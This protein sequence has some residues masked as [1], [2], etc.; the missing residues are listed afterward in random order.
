MGDR[1]PNCNGQV[2]SW[3]DL[4]C[5][6]CR[7]QAPWG[8]VP[9]GS[10]SSSHSV[11]PSFPTSPIVPEALTTHHLLRVLSQLERGEHSLCVCRPDDK[12]LSS[13]PDA[14]QRVDASQCAV[15]KR[16]VNSIAPCTWAAQ[17]PGSTSQAHSYASASS[18]MEGFCCLVEL[19]L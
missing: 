16:K 10:F 18:L 2:Q 1:G 8:P 12:H 4:I 7:V 5:S 11:P 17:P 14:P 6:S 13:G 9:A 3:A 19:V 15:S